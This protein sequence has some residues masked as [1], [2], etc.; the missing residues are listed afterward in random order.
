MASQVRHPQSTNQNYNHTEVKNRFKIQNVSSSFS[1]Q[2]F[3]FLMLVFW[4]LA[5]CNF[6]GQRKHTVSIFRAEVR[7]MGSEELI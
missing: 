4:A 1:L 5:P 6:A 7:K 2:Y 3:T